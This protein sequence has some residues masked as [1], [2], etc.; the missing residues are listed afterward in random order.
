[1]PLDVQEF[2]FDELDIADYLVQA[3]LLK[4]QKIGRM[5]LHLLLYYAQGWYLALYESPLFRSPL[6]KRGFGPVSPTVHEA[7][8][9]FDAK[10]ITAPVSPHRPPLP[11]QIQ[12][13]LMDIHQFYG[14]FTGPALANMVKQEAPFCQSDPNEQVI[15]HEAMLRFFNQQKL[16]AQSLIEQQ[17]QAS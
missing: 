15:S 8:Q 16:K 9:Q 2:A 7:F 1:M 14:H 6:H 11:E 4:Q 17:R 10:P 12:S 3:S 13:F 5:K